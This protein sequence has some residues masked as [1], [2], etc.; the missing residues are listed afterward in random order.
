MLTNN[1]QLTMISMSKFK[2]YHDITI[3]LII[4]NKLTELL[5][6]KSES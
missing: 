6:Y 1:R 3:I 5:S 4:N 2:F